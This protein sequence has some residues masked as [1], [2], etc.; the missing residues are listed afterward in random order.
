MSLVHLIGDSPE[1]PALSDRSHALALLAA[2]AMHNRI[3]VD[4]EPGS[5]LITSDRIAGFAVVRVPVPQQTTVFAS[6]ADVEAAMNRVES[7]EPEPVRD[8]RGAQA[9]QYR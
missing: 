3:L 1:L 4:Y 8:S 5:G 2:N 7:F 6:Q 9:W